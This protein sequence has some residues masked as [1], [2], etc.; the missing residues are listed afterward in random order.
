[1]TTLNFSITI[2]APKERVWEMLW[3]DAS[4]RKWTAVFSEGIS[5]GSYAES[6]WNEGSKI[7]FLS[8]N[9]D[10]MFSIIKKKVPNEQMIFEHQG[11]IKNGVETISNWAGSEEA[12]YL[13]ETN[14]VTELKVELDSTDDFKE[15]FSDTFPKALAVLKE[16]S[17]QKSMA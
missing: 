11:E 1:M 14:G 12:Y 4:Y 10:G 2:N 17:E 6:D 7:K 8:A 9:G 13:K 15:Y 3:N 5:E 16:I